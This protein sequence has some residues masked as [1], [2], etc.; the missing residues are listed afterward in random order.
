MPYGDAP[1]ALHLGGLIAGILVVPAAYKQYYLMPLPIACVFA[2][3]GLAFL[4]EMAQERVAPV[5]L[6]RR[7]RPA[8]DL[9]GAST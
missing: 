1:A 3:Q 6:R 2:A 5:A 4:V 9:A 8:L 7:D